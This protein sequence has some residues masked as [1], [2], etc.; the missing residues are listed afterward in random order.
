VFVA[1]KSESRGR[2]EEGDRWREEEKII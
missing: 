1:G 2:R